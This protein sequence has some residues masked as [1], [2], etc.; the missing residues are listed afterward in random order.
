M[1]VS[2]Q[3][4]ADIVVAGVRNSEVADACIGESRVQIAQVCKSEV[5][6]ARVSYAD[7]VAT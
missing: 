5:V 2:S 7:V 4:V 6:G 3:A 1:V